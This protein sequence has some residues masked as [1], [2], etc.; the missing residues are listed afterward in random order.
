MTDLA[1]VASRLRSAGILAIP[2][3]MSTKAPYGGLDWGRWRDY[4]DLIEDAEFNKAWSGNPTAIAIVCGDVELLDVDTDADPAGDIHDRFD[5]ELRKYLEPRIYDKLFIEKSPA[6]GIHYWYRVESPMPNQP[7]L[8][9]VEYDEG[10]QFAL[11]TDRQYGTVIETRGAGGYGICAPSPNYTI[12]QGSIFELTTL[13]EEHRDIIWQVA[14]SFNTYVQQDALYQDS[15][16][17]IPGEK[18]RPGDIYNETVGVEDVLS[19]FTSRGWRVIRKMGSKVFLNRP[20]AK[21]P[22]KHDADLC[23]RRRTFMNYSSSVA[24]FPVGR[25]H[26]FFSAY[27]IL[28]HGHDVKAAAKELASKGYRSED[29]AVAPVGAA[30][31]GVPDILEE[32]AAYKFSLSRRPNVDY[33][34]SIVRQVNAYRVEEDGVGFPGAMIVVSGEE[35]S[36][37]STLLTGI[38]AAAIKGGTVNNASFKKKCRVLWIDTE[39]P[40]FWFWRTIWKICVQAGIEQD[41]DMLHSYTVMHLLPN[42]RV[43]KIT[44]LIE[45]LKPDVLIVDGIADCVWDSNDNK[46]SMQFIDGKAKG[47]LRN[48]VMGFYV[49]HENADK[50][51]NGKMRGHIGSLLQRKCDAGIQAR[52]TSES[53]IDVGNKLSRGARFETFQLNIGRAGILYTDKLPEWYNFDLAGIGSKE[54]EPVA[55]VVE[56]NLDDLPF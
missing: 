23:I 45:A 2:I 35:K 9:R 49:I 42:E 19:E 7:G 4:P 40:D 30:P 3:N 48:G 26:S 14:R 56:T 50:A 16:P 52:K 39:Q 28:A 55:E 8:A 24:E 36:M 34:F 10:D 21:H 51:G 13:S 53:T 47:W 46:E 15:A 32:M 27:S 25:G 18:R 44:R 6:G 17:V 29:E 1:G 41:H 31:E 37:K 12:I 54:K 38:V 20:G 43:D 22:M 11:D 33:T 5:A